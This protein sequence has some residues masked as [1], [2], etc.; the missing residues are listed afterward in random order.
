LGV[1]G[2]ALPPTA[3]ISSFIYTTH[4]LLCQHF[5]NAMNNW[6]RPAQNNAKG[7]MHR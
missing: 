4:K 1:M 2:R 6:Q 3:V 7:L 5:F